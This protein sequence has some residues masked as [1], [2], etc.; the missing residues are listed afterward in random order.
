VPYTPRGESPIESEDGAADSSRGNTMNNNL[1]NPDVVAAQ[2]DVLTDTMFQCGTF[3]RMWATARLPTSPFAMSSRYV[4]VAKFIVAGKHGTPFQL[5]YGCADFA[6]ALL[7]LRS[8]FFNNSSQLDDLLQK[9]PEVPDDV[10]RT[11]L[12]LTCKGN[13]HE[14]ANVLLSYG[15]SPESR[16]TNGVP[17]LVVASRH[18]SDQVVRVLLE[19]GADVDIADPVG[20]TSWSYICGLQS[21]HAVASILSDADAIKNSNGLSGFNPLYIASQAGHVDEVR[22]MLK[23]GMNPSFATIS[24]WYALVS[25]FCAPIEGLS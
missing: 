14:A 25:R 8:S 6:T 17:Y 23:R 9:R 1:A 5:V 7:V 22:V 20:N 3:I 11:A 16:D 10:L 18:S 15:A 2:I 13:Q 4:E 21:H 24:G 12:L 19:S